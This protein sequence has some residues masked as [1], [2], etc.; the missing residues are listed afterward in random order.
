EVPGTY[1]IGLDTA[2]ELKKHRLVVWAKHGV[3]STGVS[4]Q[5]CF[6]LIETADKAA[7]IALKLRSTSGKSIQDNNILTT[8][9]LEKVCQKLQ[10][11]GRYLL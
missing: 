4:Y 7:N 2:H 10:V 3:L 1:Q 9:D 11:K 6:G 5:D 8:D